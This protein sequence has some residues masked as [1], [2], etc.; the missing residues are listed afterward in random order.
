MLNTYRM[1]KNQKH[2]LAYSGLGIQMV[3]TMLFFLWVGQK[4][5]NYILIQSPWGQLLGLF[6]GIFVSL[7]NL[8]KSVK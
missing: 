6:F 8:L 2:W 7:Y 1:A 4:I 5:E 3:V